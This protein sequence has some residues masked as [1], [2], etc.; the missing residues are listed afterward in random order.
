MKMLDIKSSSFGWNG[1]SH[2]ESYVTRG[3]HK[4]L[5]EGGK[6][7]MT[8]HPTI[9]YDTLWRTLSFQHFTY[10]SLSLIFILYVS[11][12]TVSKTIRAM[13][14]S[15]WNQRWA[16]HVSIWNQSCHG[17]EFIQ[18]EMAEPRV[19]GVQRPEI[20]RSCGIRTGSHSPCTAAPSHRIYAF[21]QPPRWRAGVRTWS[22]LSTSYH[23]FS[24]HD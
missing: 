8:I 4:S 15:I 10:G 13:H 19:R 23:R 21:E 24:T 18:Y 12:H 6:Y 5:R 9:L 14:I 17:A 22:W 11:F 3:C 7:K 2:L 1:V 20:F 16:M